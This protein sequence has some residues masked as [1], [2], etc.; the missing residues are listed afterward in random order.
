SRGLFEGPV[1][2]YRPKH[3]LVGSCLLRKG[4]PLR[5]AHDAASCPVF[6]ASELSSRNQRGRRSS[7]VA[8]LGRH[9]VSKIQAYGGDTPDGLT[10]LGLGLRYVL[11]RQSFRA[12]EAG[13]YQGFHE[14]SLAGGTQMLQG[15]SGGQG[16]TQPKWARGWHH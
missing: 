12:G 13:N 8:A 14:G 4:S 5:I 3:V 11:N 1:L 9:K 7:G 6:N 16:R 10:R 2:R 15:E